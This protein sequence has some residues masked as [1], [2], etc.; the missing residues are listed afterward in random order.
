MQHKVGHTALGASVA[1]ELLLFV[2]VSIILAMG[3]DG[4]FLL[5]DFIFIFTK[6]ILFFVERLFW[7]N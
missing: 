4:Y 1:N 3:Q 6:V 7:D 2:V 5:S